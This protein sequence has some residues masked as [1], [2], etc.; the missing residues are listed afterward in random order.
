[1]CCVILIRGDN[2][3][4]NF[5]TLLQDTAHAEDAFSATASTRLRGPRFD[6][7]HRSNHKL[8]SSYASLDP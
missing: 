7:S 1:M 6:S 3:D 4:D 2:G 5:G 8:S